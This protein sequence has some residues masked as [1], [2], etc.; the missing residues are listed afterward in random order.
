MKTKISF[1]ARILALMVALYTVRQAR[2]ATAVTY[3]YEYVTDTEIKLTDYSGPVPADL[4]LPSEIDGMTVVCIG[5]GFMSE[6]EDL[7]KVT[8][9]S[10]VRVIERYA[11]GECPNL[12]RVT[13]ND[14][15]EKVEHDAFRDSYS[16]TQVVLPHT[17][18]NIGEEAFCRSGGNLEKGTGITSISITGGDNDYFSTE[19]GLLYDKANKVVVMA[20]ANLKTAKIPAGCKKIGKCAFLTC[21][22]LTQVS[23]PF[24]LEIVAD[25]AFAGCVRLPKV[26]LTGTKVA[27]VSEQAFCFCFALT[28]A[29]FPTTLQTMGSHV[30]GGD[31]KL[32]KVTYLGNAPQIDNSAEETETDYFPDGDIYVTSKN[33]KLHDDSPYADRLAKVV[34]YVAKGT[35][36]W[37]TVPGTWQ[38][39]PIA[40]LFT[41]NSS[42]VPS[43]MEGCE[44]MGKVSG[45]GAVA[46]GKSASL[47]ATA[48]K[49]YVFA[50][51]YDGAGNPISGGV[52]YRTTPYTYV[53]TGEP[54]QVFAKFVAKQEDA[55]SLAVD[56]NDTETAAD[57]SLELDLGECVKS[58]SLP[59]LTVTGLPAGLKYDSKTMKISGKATKPGVYAVTLKATNASV[60]A[61]NAKT[62]GFTIV[63]P[64]FETDKIAELDPATDRYS[65]VAGVPF[66]GTEIAPVAAEGYTLSVSGLPSGLKYNS[67]TGEITGTPTAKAGSYTVTF[68]ATPSAAL[69]KLGAVAEKATITIAISYPT[70]TLETAPVG[71]ASASGTAKGGGALAA[72]KKVTLAAT[73]A[74]GSV[75]AGWYRG[76][77]PLA[78][79]ADWRTKSSG[80]TTAAAAETLVAKFATAAE[81]VASLKFVDVTNC[82]A[83]A[84]GAFLEDVGAHVESL[85]LPTVTVSGLPAGLKFDAKTMK[86]SGKATK[87]GVYA[88]TLKAT[89]AS[90]VAKNAKTAGF[91]IRVPN[92]ETD[93]IAELDPATDRYSFVAG[94]PFAGTEIAPVA[95][96]GYTLSVSGLPSGLKY[97]SKTG[98]IT[99]TPTAKAGSYT[100]TFTAT[101]SAA[102]KKQGAVA[103]KATI[104]VLVTYPTLTLAVEVYDEEGELLPAADYPAFY[105]LFK[106]T[107]AGSHAANK[108]VSLGATAAKEHVFGGWHDAN[109]V[110][111][112]NGAQDFRTSSGYK[113][114]TAATD[115][116]LVARFF[117]REFDAT[118][119]AIDLEDVYKAGADGAFD[120]FLDD[121]ID[122]RSLP[123]L[124]VSGLPSGLKY[125]AKSLA[126][127]GTCTKPGVY[128]VTVKATNASIKKATAD[129]TSTFELVVP[130]IQSAHLA[131]QYDAPYELTA[132]IAEE[133]VFTLSP[134]GGWSVSSVSG[135]PAGLSW[136]KA[137]GIVS[138]RPTKAGTFTVTIALKNG[139]QSET[140]TVTARVDPLPAW[141]VGTFYGWQ[142]CFGPNGSAGAAQFWENPYASPNVRWECPALWE[143]TIAGDGK[144]KMLYRDGGGAATVSTRLYKDAQGNYWFEEVVH[145][146]ADE[147]D[148][149]YDWKVEKLE[150]LDLGFVS[151]KWRGIDGDSDASFTYIAA[152]QNAYA[153]KPGNLPLP[154]FAK[155]DASRIVPVS[156]QSGRFSWRQENGI[157]TLTF[158]ANGAVTP[159][160]TGK[161]SYTM[162]AAHLIPYGVEGNVVYAKLPIYGYVRSREDSGFGLVYDLAIPCDANGNAKAAEIELE[163]EKVIIDE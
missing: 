140:A 121:F 59:K 154:T 76:G 160:W 41:W 72:N 94:V 62:A 104:T 70:L 123:T 26:D 63:V 64:N 118:T 145:T 99:G 8:I 21:Q 43:V 109:G 127:S 97:N 45:G 37:G 82:T 57:G 20:C 87:P 10:S 150:G 113:W 98:E 132:G 34:S 126:I 71:D 159:K 95:A 13:F 12:M 146:D 107:G 42:I 7:Q 52:D 80:Y 65:F 124:T 11:F 16:L 69:K 9:P 38:D 86:I 15:L 33:P 17:I 147:W 93:K 116:T 139:R 117:H 29:A 24:S 85:S 143:I 96:E 125:D 25:E 156:A 148:I 32:A 90:V 44:A 56:V 163:L 79:G 27:E 122:S 91:T 51:W 155:A 114:T 77:A 161:P 108:A 23:F 129:T 112:A 30:F 101:P 136:S 31:I 134:T 19:G 157:L 110:P 50:G 84:A 46:V 162:L 137:T 141:V 18:K 78:G 28:E 40:Y 106:V 130:N 81:D 119:F 120:L 39:R 128:A 3:E 66:A 158:G 92:L 2:A 105:K 142:D 35:T 54:T 4:T 149:G 111:L 47:K 138:G 133:G 152:Y 14:G 135:L 49:G 83:A 144:V 88:V 73:P 75:F 53:S 100:V 153:S 102:L 68:T 74:K 89:N 115:E 1:A 67:K 48:G 61:K 55:A 151:G 36:G 58:L 5:E 6:D 60:A 22:F 131:L 103:E